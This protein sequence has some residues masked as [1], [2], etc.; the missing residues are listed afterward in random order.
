MEA[1]WLLAR[2][3]RTAANGA[4][5]TDTFYREVTRALLIQASVDDSFGLPDK[6]EQQV[7]ALAYSLAAN[8]LQM[9]A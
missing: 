1:S 2:Q 6:T 8:S 3:K 7:A 4:E 9:E 5:Q